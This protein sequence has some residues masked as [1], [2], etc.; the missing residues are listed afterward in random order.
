[1][2][3]SGI[4]MGH[5]RSAA[6]TLG[7]GVIAAVLLLSAA[8]PARAQDTSTVVSNTGIGEAAPVRYNNKFEA[9]GGLNLMTF[10][11]GNL[12]KRANLGGGEVLGTYWLTRNLGPSLDFRAEAGTTQAT[13]TITYR[14]LVVQYMLMAGSEWRGPR[15]QM[16]SLD[17]HGYFGASDGIFNK[18]LPAGTNPK[19]V[20]LFTNAT[21][22]IA[23]VGFSL[24]YNRSAHW[25]IRI[26]PD[27][28]MTHFGNE[29]EQSFA[30]S[31]GVV[32]RFH[33]E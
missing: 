1:M 3:I 30:L 21:K 27:M 5:V 26:S 14:P 32:Y 33:D 25:A 13:P 31:I 22:P 18:S 10:T 8:G 7:A 11:A 20:G 24:D 12:P 29:W 28:M 19:T 23:A 17:Y 6:I 4:R 16:F 15:N 9:Y 2:Q